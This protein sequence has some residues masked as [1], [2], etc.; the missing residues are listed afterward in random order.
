MNIRSTVSDHIGRITLDRPEKRNA[1]TPDMLAA[2][3]ESIVALDENDE[4]RCILLAGAGPVF[5]AG[6]DLSLCKKNSDA[7]NDLLISLSEAI[8]ALRCA[9]TPVVIAAHGAAIAGGCALLAAG[10]F[11]F[12]DAEARI[13]YPVVSLGIS[14]AVNAPTLES[15]LTP[16]DARRRLLDPAIIS[17]RDA[18]RIGLAHEC[19][20]APDQVLPAAQALAANLAAKPPHALAATRNW[21]NELDPSAQNHTLEAALQTSLSLVGS[22]EERER[23]EALWAAR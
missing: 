12:T 15:V 20:D 16:A 4:A 13:G 17:G 7:L 6:F 19:L 11:I 18:Q 5:C 23:L 3:T 22:P 2:L 10:D 21:L 1:L 8:R 9:R 14:P